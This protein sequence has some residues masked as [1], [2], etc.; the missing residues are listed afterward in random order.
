MLSLQ[1]LTLCDH[2]DHSPPGSSIH[3]ILQARILE[4]LSNFL[5]QGIFPTQGSN[6]HLLHL[7][8]W[9]VGS[10]P[11]EPP[12]K[13]YNHHPSNHT[14]VDKARRE[15]SNCQGRNRYKCFRALEVEELTI[16]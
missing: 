9:Q 14:Q 15:N 11:P 5:L 7:L 1:Y 12:K 16:C 8:H 10:L 3:G 13:P 2:M 6:P 4:W